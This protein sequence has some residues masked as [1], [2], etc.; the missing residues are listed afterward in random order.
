MTQLNLKQKQNHRLGEQT[1]G[2]QRQRARM[3]WELEASKYQLLWV[4]ITNKVNS[5]GQDTILITGNNLM[6]DNIESWKICTSGK[7]FGLPQSLISVTL[8]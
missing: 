1:C 3:D 5:T 2:C 8:T 4:Q 7:C 6:A